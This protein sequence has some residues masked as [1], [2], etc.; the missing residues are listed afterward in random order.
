MTERGILDTCTLLLLGDGLDES[1]LPTYLE[2]TTVTLA[3]LSV[4]PLVAA[5]EEERIVR[6]GHLQ[7]AEAEFTPLPFDVAAARAFG[8]VSASIR[9]AGRSVNAR[10]LDVMIA[11]IAIANDLPVFT[12]NP[13]DFRGIDGLQLFAV[14]HP[15]NA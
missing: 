4:G 2:I 12:C 1:L 8:A 5:S 10:S 15:D 7:V 14:P 9:R 11:S 3:E 13:R 6:Q